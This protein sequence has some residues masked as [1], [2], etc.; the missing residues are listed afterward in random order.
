MPL[1]IA[2]SG[3][4]LVDAA[5]QPFFFLADTAWNTALKAD[6]P[7]WDEF[8]TAR[9]AQ[10]FTAIQ[11]VSTP[12]RGCREPIHG[13]LFE[14]TPNGVT[15]NEAAWAKMEEWLECLQTHGL[16]PVPVILWDNNPDDPIFRRRE[17]TCIAVGRRMLERW[18]RFDPIWLLAGD[19]DYR[20]GYQEGKWKRIGRGIFADHPDAL[21]TMH[22]CGTTWVGDQFDQELWYNLV[23]FQSGH[24]HS[25]T[26]LYSLTAGPYS[27]RWAQIQKPFLNLEPNYEL[28]TAFHE[29]FVYEA[30]HVRRALWWSLLGAPFAGVTYGNEPTWVWPERP[31][32]PAEGHGIFWGAGHWRTGLHTEA[33]GQLKSLRTILERLPWTQLRPAD[34]L[35]MEQPGWTEATA[36]QKCA[37]TED[38]AIVLAYLPRGGG[39]TLAATLLEPAR[40]ALWVDPRTADTLPC[41]VEGERGLCRAEAPDDR[42]WLLQ[43]RTP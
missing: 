2:S 25:R 14:E 29:D 40:E 7:Q 6:R 37:A 19:G 28:A 43:L 24:G 4:H 22:P 30:R 31:F 11:F 16:I 41:R 26:D 13:A 34:E 17:D 33:I 39:I 10:G 1:S 38:R 36:F 20:C 27:Y 5:G 3:R 23:G 35:L 15:F 12:W 9:Q 18:S 8:L 32:E 21:A 42:D